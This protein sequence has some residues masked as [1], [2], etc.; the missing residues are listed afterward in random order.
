MVSNEG[1]SLVDQTL[2]YLLNHLYRGVELTDKKVALRIL[3]WVWMFSNP[4]F[5]LSELIVN[6][7]IKSTY[8]AYA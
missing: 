1:Q 6:K 3:K 2:D 8:E 4:P 7:Q 5:P